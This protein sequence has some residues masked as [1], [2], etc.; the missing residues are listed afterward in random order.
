MANHN[1]IALSKI[2]Q[3]DTRNQLLVIATLTIDEMLAK[4]GVR[5]RS[6]AFGPVRESAYRACQNRVAE[7]KELP[8]EAEMIGFVWVYGGKRL[9]NQWKRDQIQKTLIGGNAVEDDV[10]TSPGNYEEG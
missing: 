7:G 1:R 10:I 2:N 5:S 8:S 3:T 4:Y 6:E 9:I